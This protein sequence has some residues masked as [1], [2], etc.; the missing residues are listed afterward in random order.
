MHVPADT[1]WECAKTGGS[2]VGHSQRDY[3]YTHTCVCV[4]ARASH[5][6]GWLLRLPPVVGDATVD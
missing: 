1:F 3:M 4:C 6:L 2:K 5:V